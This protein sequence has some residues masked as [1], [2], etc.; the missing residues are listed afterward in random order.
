[1]WKHGDLELEVGDEELK[2]RREEWKPPALEMKGRLPAA[3]VGPWFKQANLGADLDFSGGMTGHQS[4]QRI[5]LSG[6]GGI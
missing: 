2:S 5:P 4:Y 3:Y 1:M 6:D